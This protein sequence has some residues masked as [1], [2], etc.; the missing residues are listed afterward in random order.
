MTTSEILN[1]I[2]D[3]SIEEAPLI[4]ALFSLTV[5]II[6]NIKDRVLKMQTVKYEYKLESFSTMYK[7]LLDFT[8]KP[9]TSDDIEML[10]ALSIKTYLL[11]QNKTNKYVDD[12]LKLLISNKYNTN[13]YLE[14]VEKLSRLLKKDLNKKP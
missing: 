12:I 14:K 4:I 13:E 1:I 5:S 3:R 9:P 11:N 8:E 10:K 7:M 2:I 6:T